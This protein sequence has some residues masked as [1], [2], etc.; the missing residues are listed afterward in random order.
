MYFAFRGVDAA[1]RVVRSF[2]GPLAIILINEPSF[3]VC[4]MHIGFVTP[5][6]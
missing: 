2:I 6:S 3:P 1:M 4:S 5:P